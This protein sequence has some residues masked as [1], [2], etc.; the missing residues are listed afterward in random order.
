MSDNWIEN[1][2]ELLR[3][4]QE[5]VNRASWLIETRSPR[6]TILGVSREEIILL[7]RGISEYESALKRMKK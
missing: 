3:K 1:E 7:C 2:L 5:K 4:L 6:G